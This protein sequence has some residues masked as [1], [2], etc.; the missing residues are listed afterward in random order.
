MSL[1]LGWDFALRL[2]SRATVEKMNPPQRGGIKAQSLVTSPTHIW[3][4]ARYKRR[5]GP[6]LLSPPTPWAVL[7]RG[8]ASKDA[9]QPQP[10]ERANRLAR[11]PAPHGTKTHRV[12]AALQEDGS[13]A[14][15]IVGRPSAKPV[16]KG[17]VP[18]LLRYFRS[19]PG[20][21]ASARW[22]LFSLPDGHLWK[23]C[24]TPRSP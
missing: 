14:R 10:T 13:T 7:L 19:S 8:Y 23:L 6:R 22:P 18:D 5:H 9:Y 20:V 15:P 3:D 1:A 11:A 17:S 21:D 2:T 12:K 16:E 24:P 4:T